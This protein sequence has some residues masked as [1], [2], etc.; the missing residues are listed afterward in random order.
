VTSVNTVSLE[1][2]AVVYFAGYLIKKKL[3]HFKCDQ[4]K[5][6]FEEASY[7]CEDNRQQLFYKNYCIEKPCALKNPS[8]EM[9]FFTKRGMNVEA[10]YL[11]T[12]WGDR[13]FGRT[14]PSN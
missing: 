11:K 12:F 4:C 8:S 9:I 6:V 5:T 7:L 10:N 1:E 13:H 2:C 3:Q 14:Y